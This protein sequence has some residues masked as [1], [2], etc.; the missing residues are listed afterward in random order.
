MTGFRAGW[1]TNYSLEGFRYGIGT[2]IDLSGNWLLRIELTTGA[3]KKGSDSSRW[4]TTVKNQLHR[5]AFLLERKLN[6]HLS[7]HGGI[8][9]NLLQTKYYL[10]DEP[11]APNKLV[12]MMEATD[13]RL[14]IVKPLYTII[15]NSASDNPS[16]RQLW[17]G[18]QAGVIYRLNF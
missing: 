17:I 2:G 7:I 3:F 12:P 18:L 14:I 6:D 16:S 11:T 4:K 10:N 15:N 5:A 8:L 1:G 13:E 9:V